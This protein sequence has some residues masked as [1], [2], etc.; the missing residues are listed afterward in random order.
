MEATTRQATKVIRVGILDVAGVR[1]GGT[2]L[3]CTLSAY[4][5]IYRVVLGISGPDADAEM[6]HRRKSG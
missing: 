4:V 3:A 5:S 1:V 2:V 6:E